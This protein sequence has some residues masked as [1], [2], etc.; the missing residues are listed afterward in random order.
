MED[1]KN[2]LE[3]I[4]VRNIY[5]PPPKNIKIKFNSLKLKKKKKKLSEMTNIKTSD[6]IIKYLNNFITLKNEDMIIDDEMIE[7]FLNDE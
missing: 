4:Y 6:L 2:I 7:R 5:Y 3:N 1:C